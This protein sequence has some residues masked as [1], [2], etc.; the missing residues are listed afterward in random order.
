MAIRKEKYFIRHTEK[1]FVYKYLQSSNNN[2]NFKT[3]KIK[4]KNFIK[5][6]FLRNFLLP[7]ILFVKLREFGVYNGIVFLKIVF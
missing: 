2:L 4:I 5:W 1:Y 3:K 6:N 7:L